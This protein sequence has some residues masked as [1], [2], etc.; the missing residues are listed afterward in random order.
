[1]KIKVLCIKKK[2]DR[3]ETLLSRSCILDGLLDK[4]ARREILR[5]LNK[6]FHSAR[7]MDH[8]GKL[9]FNVSSNGI[10]IPAEGSLTRRKWVFF[11]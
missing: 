1:M 11:I 6:S 8:Q 7:T 3:K 9:D 10:T 5:E 4:V 2:E